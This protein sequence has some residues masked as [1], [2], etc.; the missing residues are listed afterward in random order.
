MDSKQVIITCAALLYRESTAGADTESSVDY[1]R[2]LLEST[3]GA[4]AGKGAEIFTKLKKLV[5]DM[6][7]NPK[8]HVYV[9]HDVISQFRAACDTEEGIF[10][11]FEM[12]LMGS[13]NEDEL[14][15]SIV[16][17]R[18]DL[19]MHEKEERLDKILSTAGFK[20][21]QQR[22][23]IKSI[24]KFIMELRADLE[25]Y[26]TNEAV[27]DPAV[28]GSLDFAN[29]EEVEKV[30]D[31]VS[32]FERGDRV[33]KTGYQ[34]INR[35]LD[36]G[37]WGGESWVLGGLQHNWKTGLSLSLFRDFAIYNEPWKVKEGKKPLLLR[38]SFEDPLTSNLEF[39]YSSFKMMES[40]AAFGEDT[41]T[42]P[43]R[44]LYVKQKLEVNGWNVWMIHVSPSMW[45]YKSIINYV[46]EL[47]AQGYEV[48][49]LMLDY[50]LKISKDG[51]EKGLAAGQDVRAIYEKLHEFCK[52]RRI[53]FIT[54][55]QLSTQAKELL[56][57]GAPRFVTHL[58]GG[59]YYADSKQIDQVIDG[60]IFFHIEKYK[61]ES[62]FTMQLGKQRRN[63]L[64]AEEFRYCVYKFPR[65]GPIIPDVG[66]VNEAYR[67]V[68]GEKI[69]SG[70]EETE[71]WD[72][73]DSAEDSI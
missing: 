25:K 58:P 24:P 66:S 23:T 15:Q 32:E 54:P 48:C 62:W 55:H 8:D 60:E 47:E 7:E 22:E 43:E 30:F 27:K 33:M 63:K 18:R 6:C 59:G 11:S 12:M 73:N 35:M 41:R 70:K 3:K 13:Y 71:F 53:L 50:L 61:R 42:I 17:L 40:G 1:V 14:K 19:A 26:E 39:L 20:Y 4:G 72:F 2:T 38:I 69:S 34:E 9:K 31:D 64:T 10:E 52:P 5:I 67:R 36:G 29:I 21:R 65:S 28:V 46:M 49:C 37:F 56:R 45:G 44:A 57:T 51:L 68:G 16:N